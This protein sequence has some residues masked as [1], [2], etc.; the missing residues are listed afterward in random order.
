MFSKTTRNRLIGGV[1]LTLA[2]LMAGEAG[3]AGAVL[4]TKEICSNPA[5]II[6]SHWADKNHGAKDVYF[7]KSAGAVAK[8]NSETDFNDLKNVFVSAHGSTVSVG[9]IA[10][11]DF[12]SFFKEAHGSTPDVMFF[13]SC[14]TGSGNVRKLLNDKYNQDIGSLYGPLGSCALV[15]NGSP[16]LTTAKNLYNVSHSNG[17]DFQ[18]V[19]ANINKIWSV[20]GEY[21]DTGKTWKAACAEF[22]DPLNAENLAEFHNAVYEEFMVNAQTDDVDTS[23]NYGLLIKWNNAGT[24]FDVCGADHEACTN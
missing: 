12:A 16:D 23:H 14:S 18:K 24:E 5:D 22:V 15:G 9:G 19:V 1:A 7:M 17:E 10:N 2:G 11:A 6:V 21:K 13:S 3:A 4:L 20:D 8:I